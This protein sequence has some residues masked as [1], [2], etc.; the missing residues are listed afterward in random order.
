VRLVYSD[1]NGN[2]VFDQG[3]DVIEGMR[4][5]PVEKYSWSRN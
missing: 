4:L 3:K 5:N 1:M 2:G